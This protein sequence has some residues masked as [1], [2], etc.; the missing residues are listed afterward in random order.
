MEFVSAASR[1]ALVLVFAAAVLGKTGNAESFRSFASSVETLGRVSAA[2]APVLAA[3]VVLAEAAGALLLAWPA[4]YGGRL[5]A[6]TGLLTATGL[7]A[8][9]TYAVARALRAGKRVACR[10]FGTSAGPVGPPQLVRNAVLLALAA[11]AAPGVW[12]G[13]HPS[14]QARFAAW[15]CGATAALVLV[16]GDELVTLLRPAP[17]A[18]TR[19]RV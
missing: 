1:A 6:L 11:A 7:L 14:W 16:V 15:L 2:R 4:T 9:F 10:C 12:E 8:S 18:P 5:P 13:G 3:G 19:T 17:A